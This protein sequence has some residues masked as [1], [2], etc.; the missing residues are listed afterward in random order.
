[1]GSNDH[2]VVLGGGMAGLLTAR[3]L[4]DT[5]E[6]VTLVERDPLPTAVDHR[7]GAP[8]DQHLHG[9]LP[10]GA[11]VVEDLFPGLLDEIEAGGAPVM[12]DYSELKFSPAGH[13]LSR[14]A[15]PDIPLYLSSRPYLEHHIRARVRALPNIEILDQCDVVDLTSTEANDRITGARVQHRTEGSEEETLEADLVVDAMGRGARTPAWLAELGYNRPEEEELVVH[16]SYSSRLLRLPPDSLS[17]KLIVIGPQP[18][19]PTGGGLI[20]QE[21]G[22]WLLSLVACVGVRPPTEFEAML[23][24]AAEFMPAHV[25]SALRNAESVGEVSTFKFPANRWRHYERLRDF[26]Q[27][28]LAIGDAFCSFNPIYGQGMSA[29]ALQ[30]AALRD[31][32]KQG[33]HDLPRRFFRS[34]ATPM[35]LVWQLAAGADLALP[36]VEGPRPLPVRI[37]NSYVGRLQAESEHD[38]VLAGQFIR[39]AFLVDPPAR[40]L[41][42]ATVLRVMTGKWRRPAP[43][44]AA[45]DSSL[46]A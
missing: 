6:R 17:E 7:R 45:E 4:A 21:D 12:T 24:F 39:V 25:I 29:A 42:P 10:G 43:A 34:A 36:E 38:P 41:R 9:L 22:S 28:L 23:D 16:L 8:Q 35:N 44:S 33:T 40:L 14:D 15:K 37:L 5:Y 1:M 46:Q 18:G 2:A 20:L 3:V 31:C 13:L 32:L 30:T 26:P 27:G 19:R 11:Q